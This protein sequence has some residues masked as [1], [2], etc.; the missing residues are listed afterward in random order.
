VAQGVGP[1][2]KPWYCKKRKEREREN[3]IM[4]VNFL[5]GINAVN[6]KVLV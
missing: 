1:Q 5:S 3:E 4:D 2:F 6:I